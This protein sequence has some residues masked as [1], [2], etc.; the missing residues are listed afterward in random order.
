MSTRTETLE[1]C[2]IR[3]LYSD[4]K[5]CCWRTFHVS[6]NVAL[7]TVASQPG[8]SDQV[9]DRSKEVLLQVSGVTRSHHSCFYPL[10]AEPE[11]HFHFGFTYEN[12]GAQGIRSG[13][14][15][16]LGCASYLRWLPGIWELA[17]GE[18]ASRTSTAM[19]TFDDTS[20]YAVCSSA[21]M[22]F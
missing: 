10:A 7:A 9:Q 21:P 15:M 11:Y 12:T 17:M 2:S 6:H 22:E 14:G 20:P 8:R 13:H 19:A 18:S 3:I 4:N 1:L 5:F 16:T